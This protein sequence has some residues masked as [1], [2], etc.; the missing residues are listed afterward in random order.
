MIPE[1][2]IPFWTRVGLLVGLMAVV[3]GL[4]WLMRRDKATRWREYLFFLVV[5][6]AGAVFGI[7]VDQV[8]SRLSLE[9][10]LYAKSLDPDQFER[11][12]V[13]LGARVG[14]TAAAFYG[15]AFLIVNTSGKRTKSLP[16][17]KLYSYLGYPI[18]GSVLAATLLGLIAYAFV[19]DDFLGR[20]QEILLEEERAPFRIVAGAHYGLYLG[21][22]IG[23]VIGVVRIRRSRAKLS[24]PLRK[25][26][27]FYPS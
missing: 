10:F 24:M 14:L 7:L 6:I 19:P 27:L 23:T 12:L 16:H 25:L 21:G 13:N 20:Y 5:L 9:Y 22:I 3:A 8:T 18:L 1:W 2:T 15:G 17:R 26:P 4:E 11:E